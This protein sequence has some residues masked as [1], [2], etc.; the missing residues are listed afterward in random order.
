MLRP[1]RHA[2]R[3]L[4]GQV[5]RPATH[6]QP[7]G[8]ARPRWCAPSALRSAPVSAGRGSRNCCSSAPR[9]GRAAPTRTSKRWA[10]GCFVTKIESLIYPEM[11]ELVYAH[12][13]QGHTV[14]LS[15]SATSYQVEP[16]ARFLGIDHVLCNRFAVKDGVLTGEVERPVLWGRRQGRRGAATRRRPRR[17]PRPELLLRRRRRGPR[18]HVPRRAPPADEPRQTPRERRG[19]PRVA[20]AC[21]SEP[22]RGRSRRAG[23]DARD[24]GVARAAHRHR[25][26]GRDR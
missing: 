11:R 1:R 3:G 10:S 5:P 24:H 14:V 18:A 19:E 8:R 15:S 22:R 13:R 6:A 17:R 4:L 20:G 7:R 26:R 2:D 9:R 16:V 23:E 12:Q 21:A 25:R